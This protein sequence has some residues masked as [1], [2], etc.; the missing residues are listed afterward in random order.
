MMPMK[1]VAGDMRLIYHMQYD[2]GAAVCISGTKD[3]SLRNV[4]RNMET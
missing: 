4:G 1:G 3:S 2:D